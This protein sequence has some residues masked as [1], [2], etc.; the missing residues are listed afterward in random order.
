M[1]NYKITSAFYFLILSLLAFWKMEKYF[2][3]LARNQSGINKV[4]FQFLTQLI[5]RCCENGKV[6]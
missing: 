1:C 2:Y 3:W 6:L 4:C 5:D